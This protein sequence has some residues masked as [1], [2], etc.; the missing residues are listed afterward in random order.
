MFL[1]V[2]WGAQEESDLGTGTNEKPPYE[3]AAL[4]RGKYRAAYFDINQQ[5]RKVKSVLYAVVVS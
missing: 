4:S 2:F 5:F 1:Y 3:G